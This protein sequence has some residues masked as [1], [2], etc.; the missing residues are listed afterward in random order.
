MIHPKNLLIQK[1]LGCK[2]YRHIKN[3]SF[4]QIGALNV[5][6]NKLFATGTTK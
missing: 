3:F 4:L 6:P 5:F 2:I 1:W